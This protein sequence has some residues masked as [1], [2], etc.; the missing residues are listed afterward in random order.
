M[1]TSRR[2]ARAGWSEVA[3]VGADE[4]NRRKGHNYVTVFA[5][6]VEKRVLFG[7]EGKDAKVWGVFAQ[8]LEAHNGDHAGGH[9][10]EKL[11]VG[12]HVI[13]YV[14]ETTQRAIDDFFPGYAK[15]FSRIR[16]ERGWAP[17]TRSHFDAARSKNGAMMTGNPEEVAEKIL[18][19][20]EALGGNAVRQFK[21]ESG[22]ALLVRGV[23]L[24]LALAELGLIDEYE[25]V[26]QPRL[27]GHGPTLFAGLTKWLPLLPI[28]KGAWARQD[29][30]PYRPQ[31]RR[32]GLK[33]VQTIVCD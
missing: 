22:K 9:A 28:R 23:K 18:R 16:K 3:R 12:I 26:V 29:V 14:G 13:G 24:P 17:I 27:A 15:T 1:R 10:P 5:D 25:F 33:R 8:E 20:S 6:L 30:L 31:P 32:D 21:R 7:T 11:K 4:M 2:R 19:H